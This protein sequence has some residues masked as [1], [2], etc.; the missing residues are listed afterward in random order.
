M[1]NL[2]GIR[3]VLMG[4]GPTL[5]N[6]CT[7]DKEENI[8]SSLIKFAGIRTTEDV[9]NNEE[10]RSELGNPSVQFMNSLYVASPSCKLHFERAVPGPSLLSVCLHAGVESQGAVAFNVST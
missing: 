6:I 3:V 4:P 10:E 5:F 2:H 7:N 8:K 9:V 1:G